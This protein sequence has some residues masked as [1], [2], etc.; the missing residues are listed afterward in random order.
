[1][2]CEFSERRISNIFPV[3]FNWK[4]P[5]PGFNLCLKVYVKLYPQELPMDL[6]NF[7]GCFSLYCRH[8]MG[9]KLCMICKLQRYNCIADHHFLN[10]FNTVPLG[11]Q[12]LHI[13]PSKFYYKPPI[14]LYLCSRSF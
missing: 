6:L 8:N 11:D 7:V 14:S 10:Y 12:Y 9:N 1:M 3:Q 2:S 5:D 4:R 13:L